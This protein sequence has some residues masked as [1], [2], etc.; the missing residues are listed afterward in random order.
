M[1]LLGLFISDEIASLDQLASDDL[2]ALVDGN[3]IGRMRFGDIDSVLEAHDLALFAVVSPN[4]NCGTFFVDQRN[5]PRNNVVVSRRF[6]LIVLFEF[7]NQLINLPVQVCT[8]FSRTG[9][10]QWCASLVNENGVHFIDNREIEASLRL[11]R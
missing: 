10:N 9:N 5:P 11:V 8:G 1:R 2:V 6:R 3:N 4:G 7:W